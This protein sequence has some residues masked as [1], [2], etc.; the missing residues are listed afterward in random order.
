MIRDLKPGTLGS[1]SRLAR[2]HLEPSF[3]ARSR[4]HL[5]MRVLN[6]QISRGLPDEGQGPASSIWIPTSVGKTSAVCLFPRLPGRLP[7]AAKP[8][9][10]IQ[11]TA[12]KARPRSWLRQTGERLG[13]SCRRRNRHQLTR[14]SREGGSPANE[15]TGS[16]S[17]RGPRDIFVN[18]FLVFSDAARKRRSRCP[19]SSG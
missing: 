12:P 10:G 3:E 6:F 8:V 1:R 4:G 17:T 7:E 13:G 11:Y 19:G 2:A 18:F 16:P 15:Q 5:R 9:S 14:G